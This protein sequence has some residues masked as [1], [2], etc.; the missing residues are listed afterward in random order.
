[1][2]QLVGSL[3]CH[4]HL[5]KLV[6]LLTYFTLKRRLINPSVTTKEI[7]TKWLDSEEYNNIKLRHGSADLINDLNDL[8]MPFVL[9]VMYDTGINIE[10]FELIEPIDIKKEILYIINEY[11]LPF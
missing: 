1:M 4:A 6:Q 11:W 10:R 7:L 2:N 8:V 3:N 5:F 9:T